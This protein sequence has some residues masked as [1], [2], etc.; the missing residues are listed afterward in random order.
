M[1]VLL[2]VAIPII[3]IWF[4]ILIGGHLNIKVLIDALNIRYGAKCDSDLLLGQLVQFIPSVSSFHVEGTIVIQVS[5][6]MLLLFH[7]I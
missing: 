1:K 5:R 6:L 2:L 7:L 4:L 3:D